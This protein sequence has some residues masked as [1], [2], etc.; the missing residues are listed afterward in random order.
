MHVTTL[1]RNTWQKLTELQGKSEKSTL[2][3]GYFNSPITVID[4]ASRQKISKDIVELNCLINQIDLIDIYIILHSTTA[5]N[6][7]LSSSH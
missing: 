7:F 2:I 3:I 1:H 4:R 5:E 6:T